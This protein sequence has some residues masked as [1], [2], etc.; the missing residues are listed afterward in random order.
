[1]KVVILA[2]GRGARAY[3][4][5]DYLPKPMMPVHGKPILLRIMELFANHGHVDFMLS[6]GYR[7]EVIEDYFEGRKLKNWEVQILDTGLDGDT[8]DRIER[9]RGHLT[10][11]FFATYGDGLSDVDLNQLLAYHRRHG[12][13]VTVTSVPLISQY[14]TVETD[15]HGRVLRFREKP[16]LTEHWINAGF[17]VMQPQ[18]FEHWHGHSL[19][20]EVL[21]A[22]L[23]QGHVYAY[24][25]D[26]FFKS[27]DTQ[28]D[29]M[30]IDDM[31]AR[32]DIPARLAHPQVEPAVAEP[33]K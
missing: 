5:T 26:G 16:R 3:P 4:F 1:M 33:C 2:G 10:E 20:R 28:K 24:R 17:F 13:L 8:G 14:G 27:M 18:V 12:G 22:L 7:K 30:E 31:Y 15:S 23:A 6:V 25:H 29:Q 32:G 21:P 9:C 11:P 19:E